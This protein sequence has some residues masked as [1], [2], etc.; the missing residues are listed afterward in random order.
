MSE[1]TRRPRWLTPLQLK[2]MVILLL[3]KVAVLEQLVPSNT[4]EE[5]K[6]GNRTANLVELA[7]PRQQNNRSRPAK[8]APPL[9]VPGQP[10]SAVAETRSIPRPVHLTQG[11]HWVFAP[12]NLYSQPV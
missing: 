10:V 11:M 1:R 8:S 6:G 3:G 4:A 5:P 9:R 7:K 12:Y 2:Q